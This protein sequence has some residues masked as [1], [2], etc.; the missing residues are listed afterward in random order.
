MRPEPASAV[1]AE[2]GWSYGE[3]VAVTC[4]D[5][6]DGLHSFHK[7]YVSDG[8][9]YRHVALVCR[10]CPKS[11]TVADVGLKRYR[12]AVEQQLRATSAASGMPSPLSSGDGFDDNRLGNH[13]RRVLARRG[14][15]LVA[16]DD[17]SMDLVEQ[18]EA[19]EDRLL[20][21]VKLNDPNEPLPETG[22][23]VDVRVLLPEGASFEPVRE[24]LENLG[25]PFRSVRYWLE[26]ETVTSV[27]A[28]GRHA[29]LTASARLNV[30]GNG[31][32]VARHPVTSEGLAAAAA[33]DAFQVI[34]DAHQQEITPPVLVP[35]AEHV[36]AAWLP[37]LPFPSLNPAQAQASPPLREGDDHLLVT[38]PTGAGKTVIGM[39]AA[40]RAILAEGRKAAWLVPQRSLTDELDRELET[41]RARGLRVE[42]LSGEHAVDVER[43]RDADLWVATTEKFES[44]CRAS[45]MQEAI[46]EVGC[47]IVDEVHLLG[48]PGR[49]PVLEALLARVRGIGSPVRVVGLSATV[50]NAGQ[51]AG[52]LGAEPVA[53]EW[54][55]T[56]LTWQLL[57]IPA[58]S[59][60][61]AAQAA[62]T[63]LTCQVTRRVT[64]DDGSVL[65]FCGSK[66]GVRLTALAIAADRGAD[67]GRVDP[68]DQDRVHAVCAAARVGLHYKDW[69][70]KQ[71][72]ERAFRDREFDV[73]V[74]T[75]TVAAGVNLPARAVIVRD[76]TL[77]RD[78]ID[79]AQVQQMFGRAGRI[80]AGETEGW[81]YL[82]VDENRRSAWQARLVDGYQVSSKIVA[83]LSDHVLAEAVQGRV[84]TLREAE[85]WWIQTLAHYQGIHSLDPLHYAVDA[86]VA[87]GYITTTAPAEAAGDADITVTDLGSLT[88]RLMVSTETGRDLREAL[89]LVPV[90]SGHVEAEELLIFLVSVLV[91]GLADAPVADEV[92]P[93]VARLLNA[94]GHLRRVGSARAYRGGG[95]AGKA[96]YKAGDL[97]RATLLTAA[98][99]PG[100]F[101]SRRRLIAGI[102]AAAMHPLL[103]EAPHYL[104]WLAGQGY[105]G[106][107]HPWVAVVA[108]D[109]ARRIRWRRLGAARG[110]GRLL[111][112]CEQMATPLHT[113]TAVPQMWHAATRRG[114][115]NPD[116]PPGA[117][118]A[119][120][121]LDTAAYRTLLRDR[122]TGAAFALSAG[123]ALITGAPGA[124]AATWKGNAHTRARIDADQLTLRFPANT[125]AENAEP[126]A[127]LFSRRGD[128]QATGWLSVYHRTGA[129]PDPA[130][131]QTDP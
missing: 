29:G 81:A 54:R 77:G 19:R 53:I 7:A 38:A 97:A 1:F 128:Y 75:T 68:D 60:P 55:P 32:G 120:C 9:R 84:A 23:G 61:A 108:A 48:S 37:Y 82:I 93:A 59:D 111:W 78:P 58:S 31:L 92:R 12:E 89:A 26:A 115:D 63:R 4:P 112:M 110:A 13:L 118:P 102:P 131:D 35:A 122:L 18:I 28:H 90:P 50:A 88:A 117:R 40:L 67:I 66:R 91:A 21:W 98:N 96:P 30:L 11:F 76:T 34:W 56:R 80:G 16:S 45:S 36:P 2:P 86:L 125:E 127:A 33:R 10:R 130:P 109:L 42:R 79:V 83:T 14:A 5:C 69:E 17:R 74:A 41:W 43:T 116:W 104:G 27:D 39:I 101:T 126:G 24:R 49:G 107:V 6:G 52:W 51:I 114:V 3:D 87:G 99:S 44:L 94:R 15:R 119:G 105:L 64:G 73:L 65:V 129:P 72:A 70:H 25:V 106:T 71:E 95:L 124:V 47:L 20:R 57:T 121:H 62:R 46:A 22:P 100:A 113:E 85:A 8:K 103:D 123:D